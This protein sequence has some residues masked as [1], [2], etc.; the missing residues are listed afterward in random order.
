MNNKIKQTHSITHL[1]AMKIDMIIIEVQT[2]GKAFMI[3]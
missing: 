2:E 3:V 1:I